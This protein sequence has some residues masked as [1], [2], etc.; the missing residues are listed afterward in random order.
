MIY[1]TPIPPD[2]ETYLREI[3]SDEYPS[4]KRIKAVAKY[5]RN[6]FA[7]E[8]LIFKA[9][10][11]RKYVSLEKYFPFRLLPWEKAQLALWLCT[12]TT[13]GFPRWDTLFDFMGRGGGKDGMI[14]FFGFC[15]VSPYNPAREYDVDI[16]ANNEDQAMRPVTDLYNMIDRSPDR[17]KLDRF[18]HTKIESVRGRENGGVI[19]GRTS[20]PGGKDGM[21]SG[22]VIL[23][24][25]HAYQDYELINVFETGQGKKDDF[26]TGIFSSNGDVSDGPLDDYIA[27]GDRILFDGEDDRGFLPFMWCLDD[28]TEVHDP[29]NWFK[30]NPSLRYFPTL[31]HKIEKE[32]EDWKRDPENHPSF[33][34]KRMGVR[35]GRAEQ[36]VTDYENVLATNIELPD[37]SGWSCTV[38]LDY[39]EFNDWAAINIHFKQGAERFDINHAWICTQGRYVNRIKPNWHKWVDMG[40]LTPVDKVSISPDLLAEY[41][42]DACKLYNV[43]MLIADHHRWTL[44][45]EAFERIGFDAND[46]KRVRL[47]RPSDIMMIEPVVQDCFTRHLF[48]WGNNPMLRWA[49]QNTKRVRSSRKIG[50]DT[51]NFYYAKIE[52]KSRKTDPFMALVHSMIGEKE[53]DAAAGPSIPIF[54][55]IEL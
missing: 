25:V 55:A 46:K 30:A 27:R 21:R 38:G 15:L 51:G 16:C 10:R 7:S 22:A 24:E 36:S 5:I 47:V 14:S 6:V 18:Y 41:V 12:Y 35:A 42:A 31:Q 8:E 9:E 50:S 53:I 34:T 44:V 43:R 33:M 37:M 28:A 48:R 11:Y 54:G 29:R 23:N 4:N 13:E 19:R 2:V 20:N 45:S 49:T 17:Q 26:R 40:L 32:Y 52:A 39:A 1:K 3:E